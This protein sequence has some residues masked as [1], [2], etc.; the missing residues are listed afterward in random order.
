MQFYRY[1]ASFITFWLLFGYL[2]INFGRGGVSDEKGVILD[3]A[4]GLEVDPGDV[5]RRALVVRVV[6]D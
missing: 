2:N 1:L 5:S 6:L 4:E 3:H